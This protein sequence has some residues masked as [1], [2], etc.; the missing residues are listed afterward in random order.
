MSPL[1]FIITILLFWMFSLS[2]FLLKELFKKFGFWKNFQKHYKNQIT[3]KYYGDK[4]PGMYTIKVCWSKKFYAMI[5][6]DFSLGPIKNVGYDIFWYLESSNDGDLY[7]STYLGKW[8]V[9]FIFLIEGDSIENINISL[10]E[11]HLS[12]TVRYTFLPHWWQKL[13]LF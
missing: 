1:I 12:T 9:E 7:F 6:F 13:D 8:C 10:A 4:K 2:L 11:E 5:G 3:W